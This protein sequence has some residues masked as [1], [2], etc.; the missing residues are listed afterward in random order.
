MNRAKVEGQNDRRWRSGPSPP[1]RTRRPGKNRR[2]PRGR[3]SDNQKT[4]QRPW[5]LRAAT[6]VHQPKKPPDHR[7]SGFPG[8]GNRVL[9]V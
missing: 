4:R 6:G 2:R 9:G 3:S 5:L 8:P 7:G 1:A